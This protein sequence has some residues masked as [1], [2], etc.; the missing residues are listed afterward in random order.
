MRL[1]PKF[2]LNRLR[3]PRI[4]SDVG[5]HLFLAPPFTPEVAASVGMISTRLRFRA[6]ESSRAVCE[7]EAN[8]MSEREYEALA[9][10]FAQ[11]PQPQKMLEIG[12]GFGRSVAYFRKKN[13]WGEM[14]EVH[15]YDANGAQTK[16]K[17]KHYSR[18]PQWPDI[19]SFCGNLQLL[20]SFLEYN[21]I[22]G[23]RIFDAAELPLRALPGPYDLIYGFFSFGYHW[24]LDFYL[25]DL[26]PLMG[27]STLLIC[28]VN[29]RFKPFPRLQHYSTRV[30][31]CR[32]TKKDAPPLHLLALSN[33]PLPEVGKTMKEAFPGA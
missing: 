8:G 23:Y 5:E 33:S 20:R 9:P 27:H 6:D 16:Y 17:H 14:A 24:S 29:K 11:L 21:I 7:K 26:A 25:D 13:V 19:S 2:S 18:P 31:E 10:L 30:L 32:D 3:G 15:L 22:S 4:L 12:P 1:F 28:T